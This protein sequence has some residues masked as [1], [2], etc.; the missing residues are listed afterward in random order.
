MSWLSRLKNA[1]NSRRLDEDLADEMRDHRE[2]RAAALQTKG[3]NAEEARR[4]AGIRFGNVTQL[5]EESRGIRLSA[6]LEST[7]QDVRYAWRGM[8]KGPAFAATAVLSL[9]LAIGANTAIYSIVDAAILRSLPV[10]AP[11]ELFRL[12]W[13][14]VSDPG[15]V[16]AQARVSFSYPM[17]LQFVAVSKDAARLTLFSYLRRVEAQ[18]PDPRVPV[19]KITR[20]FV[21][22]DA[23]DVLGVGPAAGRLL[24]PK[25]R[26]VA[27]LS[28]NYWRKRFQADPA[29]VGRSLT[30]EGKIFEIAGVARAG[31]SGVEPGKFIDVWLPASFYDRRALTESGL[32]W[33]QIVGRLHPGASREQVAARLQPA[34]HRFQV[35]RANGVSTLPLPIR[36]QFL[37]SAIQVHAAATGVTD[38]QRIFGRPLWIVFGVSA[39]ILLIACANVASLLLARAT[40]RASEMAMRVSLGA[41]RMR[42]VRQ[43]LTE[44]LLLSLTAGGL[45]W[46]LARAGGPLLVSLLSRSDDP[47]EFALAIDTRVLLFCVGVSMLSAILFGLVPAWQASGAQPMTSLKSSTGQAGK[48]RLGKVFVTIQVACAF[49]LLMAGAA[50]LFS[51]GKLFRVDPGFDARNVAVF[52][53]TTEAGKKIE[54][55]Q[56]ALMFQLRSRI[57]SEPGVEAAAL[58]AWPIFLG[59]GWEQQII[60]PGK[61]PSEQEEIFYRVSPGYFATLRTRMLTGRDFEPRDS[62]P[63]DLEPAIV[64]AA[65]ARKY[66]NN[67]NALG[68]EFSRQSG[69]SAVRSVIVGVASDAH[70]NDLRRSAEPIVYLPTEGSD[71]FTLYVRSPLPLGALV[72]MVE[73]E[74]HT[75]GAGM[76]VRDVTTLETIVGNTLLREK[77]L[78]AVGGAFAFFGLLLAGIGLFGLLSYSVGRRTKEIGIRAALGAQRRE[79]IWLVLK[80]VSGLMSGGLVIGLAGALAVMSLL[81]SLLF[82]IRVADPFVIA[83][84]MALFLVTGLLAAS[85][86]AHRAATVDPML[87]LRE[88]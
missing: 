61:G 31:F 79:V 84:A 42:L 78:A 85:L 20:Q 14:G 35:E 87:A 71:G 28:D 41:A 3:L 70:Y 51:L 13:P 74:T 49:C 4:Q 26:A 11:N 12:S 83:T 8:R 63:R 50:F 23:F 60:V 67:L 44:S 54:A 15:G 45:G 5:R 18:G 21:S 65:F 7:L 38:F 53:I 52:S 57:V 59:A 46:L 6:G 81:R 48:L 17:Y 86:P 16:P 37:R 69:N 73:R 47:V 62:R 19:E 68:R 27:V 80:D 2:R 55:A 43:M 29:I 76:R 75:V 22:E 88:Q 33:F 25:G 10:P 56:S 64:N 1:V 9:A 77:L 66:F 36:E 82:E 40:A 24:M 72:R 39:G 58:A 32:N 30:V 34:F